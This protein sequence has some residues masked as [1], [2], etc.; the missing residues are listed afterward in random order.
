MTEKSE[1]FDVSFLP[2]GKCVILDKDTK[3]LLRCTITEA[4]GLSWAI[5]TE[6]GDSD[7][8]TRD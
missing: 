3:E 5:R 6:A 7:A 8:P 1:R 4:I 2:R